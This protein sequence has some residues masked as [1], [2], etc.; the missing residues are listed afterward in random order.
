MLICT[1]ALA[2]LGGG[3]VTNQTLL[4]AVRGALREYAVLDAI[5]LPRQRLVGLVLFQSCC[6]GAAGALLALPVTL[7]L[8]E[9]VLWCGT[10]VVLPGWLWVGSPLVN[11]VLAVLSGVAALRPLGQ[12]EP[13]ALLR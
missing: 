7:A 8:A 5:G 13:A 9:L 3:V 11:L 1:V 6:I 2:L 10:H 12:M 4:A